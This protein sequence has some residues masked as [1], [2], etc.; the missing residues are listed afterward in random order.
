[1]SHF[2]NQCPIEI[3][4][5]IFQHLWA[6]EIV[7][8]FVNI[9]TY[10]N[11]ILLNYQD[12]LVNFESIRKSHFD[13]VCRYIRPEQMLSLILSDKSD[14]TPNQSKFFCSLFFIQQFHRLRS[15][16]LIELDDN[17]ES[18]ICNL[19]SSDHRLLQFNSNNYVIYHY[20]KFPVHNYKKSFDE[21]FD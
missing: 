21:L 8:S 2:L 9:S 13:L 15:L 18:L 7:Y 6:H 4:Y 10:L 19:S 20:H 1:M 17:G 14:E 16:K 12:Y 11:S 5:T 3:F